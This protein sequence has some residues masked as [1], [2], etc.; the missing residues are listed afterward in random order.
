MGYKKDIFASFRIDLNSCETK[1]L[2]AKT[3]SYIRDLF[4]AHDSLLLAKKSTKGF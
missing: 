3:K 2:F 1:M 4:T